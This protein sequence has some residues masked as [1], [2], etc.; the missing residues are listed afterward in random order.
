MGLHLQVDSRRQLVFDQSIEP[1]DVGVHGPG[2]LRPAHP[3]N[4]SRGLIFIRLESHG[5]LGKQTS[6]LGN[7]DR[8][9]PV[10]AKDHVTSPRPLWPV[11][12]RGADR[13]PSV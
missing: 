7:S 4:K 1:V 9:A 13:L 11:P 5:N 6:Q 3:Q 2:Q 12:P 8:L 10:L